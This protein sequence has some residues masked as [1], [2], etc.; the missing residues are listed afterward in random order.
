MTTLQYFPLILVCV[1]FNTV[2]Q[3]LLKTGMN[4]IGHFEFHPQNIFI[5]GWK[6]ATN[7][8]ILGGLS[9][10]VCSFIFWL[11]TLSRMD[12]SLAYPLSSVGY[13]VTAIASYFIL[14]ENISLAKIAG[15]IVIIMGVYLVSRG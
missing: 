11:M 5:I 15:I 14:Q 4:T 8:Y 10:Y 6:I 7:W 2:S 9:C 13:V 1:A 12:V 3:I